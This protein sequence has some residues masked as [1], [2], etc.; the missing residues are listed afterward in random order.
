MLCNKRSDNRV[1]N[2]FR[3]RIAV[4]TQYGP[5]LQDVAD[6]ADQHGATT[7]QDA[8]GPVGR[9]V[10]P[11]LIEPAR[12]RLAA[13]LEGCRQVSPHQAEPVPKD[14]DLI[15]AVDGGDRI[16]AIHDRRH[17]RF[18][19]HIVNPRRIVTTDRPVSIGHDFNV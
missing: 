13:F 14:Q 5:A 19:H 6:I 2:A 9:S 8:F 10:S 18:Q 1:E 4:R 11:V 15:F 3:H 16:L 12:D 7:G 17:C